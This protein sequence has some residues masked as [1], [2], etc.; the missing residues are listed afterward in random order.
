M[1]RRR[2]RTIAAV[3]VIGAAA[4]IVAFGPGTLGDRE[5]DPDPASAL[6]ED[7]IPIKK[8]VFI[9]KENRTY[10]H[11][12]GRYPGG[13][14]ARTGEY[15]DGTVV[16]LGRAPDVYPHD[17]GHDFLRGLLAMNG[18]QMNGFNLLPG[19]LDAYL[20]YTR[21][22]LPAYWAYADEYVLADRM[23]SSTFG[24]TPPEHLYMVAAQS[25]RVVTHGGFVGEHPVADVKPPNCEEPRKWWFGQLKKH[26]DLQRWEREV[27]LE[28]I[29]EQIRRIPGCLYIRSIFPE[30][31]KAGV[32]WKY[33][34]GDKQYQNIARV[35]AEIRLSE[36][37]W[38]E[39]VVHPSE[40]MEDALNGDLAEV[41]YLIPARHLNEHPAGG[42][43]ATSICVG[44]NY[45]VKLINSIM[46]GPDW[47]H[48]AI[49]VT[50]DDFGGLYD[51]QPPPQIDD[52][53]LGFRVPLLVISPYAKEG[54]ISHTRYE[55]SSFLAFME[56]RWGI[57][58][59]THR[60]RQANDMFDVFDF[61]QEPRAP[62]IIQ[63]RE[64]YTTPEGNRRC[65]GVPDEP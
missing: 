48:T 36:R 56:E 38:G 51:H 59:L 13:D 52:M 24:P 44:E 30:L 21:R 58:P 46:E 64:E 25:D 26:P 37:R 5:P 16:E 2:R 3:L 45:T 18:G 1:L 11:M 4:V 62:L 12:F 49:F 7:E 32:S 63:P 40:F 60:D 65:R 17:I 47:E 43:H 61:D 33:Y 41:N 19:G 29:K 53:G 27:D 57:E 31:E 34:A 22:D 10:D 9:I 23:F 28:S 8:V 35:L 39:N 15:N 55:F 42:E 14:G 20:Q 54:H 6:T 50:W